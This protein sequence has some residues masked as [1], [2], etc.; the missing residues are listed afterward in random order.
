[1]T[2][3]TILEILLMKYAKDFSFY[4]SFLLQANSGRVPEL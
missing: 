1:M 3:V 4:S 2:L